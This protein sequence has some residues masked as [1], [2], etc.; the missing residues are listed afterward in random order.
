MIQH[1]IVCRSQQ[2]L[3]LRNHILMYVPYFPLVLA[4]VCPPW[5]AVVLTKQAVLCHQVFSEVLTF[6]L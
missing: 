4:V 1:T 3:L 5:P 2:E 6:D